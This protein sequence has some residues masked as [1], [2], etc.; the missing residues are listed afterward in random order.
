MVVILIQYY[1]YRHVLRKSKKKKKLKTYSPLHLF[2]I[3]I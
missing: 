3:V 1:D 2:V